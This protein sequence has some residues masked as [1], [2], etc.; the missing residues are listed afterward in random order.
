MGNE[1]YKLLVNAQIAAVD[2]GAGKFTDLATNRELTT[3]T[4][5]TRGTVS[6]RNDGC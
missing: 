5:L 4:Q 2:L 6:Q 3:K 1:N